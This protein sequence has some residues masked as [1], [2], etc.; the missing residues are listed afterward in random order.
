MSRR[1]DTLLVAVLLVLLV[2]VGIVYLVPGLARLPV[3]QGA[4]PSATHPTVAL[5]LDPAV[6]RVGR[7][8][9]KRRR[10]EHREGER[11]GD[12]T[13][14]HPQTEGRRQQNERGDPR[15]PQLGEV[16]DAGEQR[17]G[18]EG[19]DRRDC[20]LGGQRRRTIT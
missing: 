3:G 6:E 10:R 20:R 15:L 11:P 17:R 12:R 4:A 9:Q 8:D 14:R 19:P 13:G 1:R 16:R 2:A 5:T 7:R 18:R